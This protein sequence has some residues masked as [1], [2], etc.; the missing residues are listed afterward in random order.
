ME[1]NL[2][3][4]N[5]DN[6]AAPSN[7]YDDIEANLAYKDEDFEDLPNITHWELMIFM[8]ILI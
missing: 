8:R 6:E 4:R 7:K 2:T 3:F 1:V 5:D